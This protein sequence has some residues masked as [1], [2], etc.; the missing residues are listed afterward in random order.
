MD[1]NLICPGCMNINED[2]GDCPVCGCKPDYQN[3]PEFLPVRYVLFGR[4]ILGRVVTVSCESAI[5]IA[6]DNEAGKTVNVKEYFPE[7]VALRADDNSVIAAQGRGRAYS[8]GCAEFKRLNEK[9]TAFD[10]PALPKTLSVF[11][12]NETVYAVTEAV[13]GITLKDF[14]NRNDG[15]LK[16]EQARPLFLPLMDT[17]NE[18]N[19][20][21][22]VHGGVS[23]E[24]IFISRDGRLRI[25]DILING[26]RRANREMAAQIYGGYAAIEQYEPERAELGAYTDVYGISATLFRVLI[27]TVPA[28]SVKRVNADTLSIPSHFAEELPR[29]VLVAMAN[30]LQV[31]PENRTETVERFRDELVYGEIEEEEDPREE[32]ARKKEKAAALKAEKKAKKQAEE[33]IG[34]E[35][36]YPEKEGKGSSVK[37]AVI[38]AGCTVLVFLIIAAILVFGPF[39]ERIFGT[40]SSQKN[41]SAEMPSVDS[42][43]DYDSNVVDSE[44]KYQVPDVLGLTMAQVT[45][46]E[47][48]KH[49]KFVIEKKVYSSK[50]A[51]GTICE[52]SVKAGKEVAADT[53]II[54]SVSLGTQEYELSDV[55]GL[56]EAEAKVQLLRQGILFDN[57]EVVEKYDSDKDKGIVLEQ[58][59]EAGGKVSDESRIR[60]YVNSYNGEEDEDN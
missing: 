46:N 5:Y 25:R 47:A 2:G 27:G 14:L 36:E 42:I 39:R 52:Q 59:P 32:K 15:R 35:A 54:V 43:G 8:E 4:Y 37:V 30:G 19:K 49:F 45:E 20:Q 50:Y 10:L 51:K 44:T 24:S 6:Y 28:E 56:S 60:I 12:S 33:E 13:M 3:A 23:P 11:E 55:T 16:W 34:E 7:G 48:N 31:L 38:T 18:L 58:S 21:G 40:S 22:I 17:L 9:L 53:T 41:S 57:I 1:I 29:Q 26:A